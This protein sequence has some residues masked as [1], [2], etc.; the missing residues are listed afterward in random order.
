MKGTRPS[1]KNSSNGSARTR[2]PSWRSKGTSRRLWRWAGHSASPS[3]F[4]L[5][6]RP[7]SGAERIR[8]LHRDRDGVGDG[9]HGF[10]RASGRRRKRLRKGD[11]V[12]RGRG[13]AKSGGGCNTPGR[14]VAPGKEPPQSGDTAEQRSCD[15]SS[16]FVRRGAR[17]CRKLPRRRGF[18]RLGRP[19]RRR[20]GGDRRFLFRFGQAAPRSLLGKRPDLKEETVEGNTLRLVR[21]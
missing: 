3:F 5:R 15:R 8:P 6:R 9:V 21:E 11:R 2:R 12:H 10:Q 18:K 1:T 17:P 7:V 16:A 19:F 20:Q 13:G 14:G 4:R